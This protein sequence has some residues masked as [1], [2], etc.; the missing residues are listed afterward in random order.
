MFS[1]QTDSNIGPFILLQRTIPDHGAFKRAVIVESD[2]CFNRVAAIEEFPAFHHMEVF[3]VRCPP[4]LRH[5]RVDLG[6]RGFVRRQQTALSQR[7][8][9]ARRVTY[10]VCDKPS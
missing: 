1:A 6:D 10:R 3:C 4:K 8:R 7:G 9:S 2:G 5:E